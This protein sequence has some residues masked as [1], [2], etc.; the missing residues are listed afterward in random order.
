MPLHNSSSTGRMTS[1]Q[2]EGALSAPEKFYKKP[3]CVRSI[4]FQHGNLP[5]YFYRR[6]L[7][8]LLPLQYRC[9]CHIT[10]LQC[11][12]CHGASSSCRYQSF[13]TKSMYFFL[14]QVSSSQSSRR[15]KPNH[16]FMLNSGLGRALLRWMTATTIPRRTRNAHT[17]WQ[18]NDTS[19]PVVAG[20]TS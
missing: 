9:S 12:S 17:A 10:T 20:I 16:A 2:G 14:P 4:P 1:C 18:R 8:K 11:S 15:E 3:S 19:R 5:H 13:G 7:G 6:L